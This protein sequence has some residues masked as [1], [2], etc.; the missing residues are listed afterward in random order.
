MHTKITVKAATKAAVSLAFGL[1]LAV[2]LFGTSQQASAG[3]PSSTSAGVAAGLPA[4]QASKIEN[5]VLQ[6]TAN[7]K[8]AEFMVLLADKANLSAANSMRDQDARGWYVYNT[9]RSHA[10][11]TQAGIRAAL[12]AAKVPYKAFWAIN[13]LVVTG[14]RSVVEAMAARSDVALIESNRPTRWIEEPAIAN[15]TPANESPNVIEW[16]VQRVNAPQV[17]AMGYTGQ[18]I[19]VANQDT[20]VR[21]THNAIRPKYRGWDGANANHNYN[22][23][24]AIHSGGGIC[25]PNTQAPCDDNGHGT[26]TV[27]TSVGE[28]ST[29]T[30]QI[31]V[32]PG[33]KW[34][35]CRNMN[36]GNGTPAT[37][38]ECFQFFIAPTDL[39]GQNPNPA[40]RPHVMNNSWGCPPSEGCSPDSLRQVIENTQAAGIFVEASAGNSGPGCGTVNDP[41]AIYEASFS[42]GATDINNNLAGFSSRGPVTVDGSNRLKPNISAPGVNV[43]S[44]TN[45]SDTSYS[46]FSGTSM[47]GPHVVGVVALLWS[48]RPHLIRDIQTTKDVLQNTA[49]PQVNVTASQPYCGG[50]PPTQIPNNYFG[51]GRVDALAAVNSVQQGTPTATVTGTPPTSTMTAVVTPSSTA[52][53]SSTPNP[54]QGNYMVT[55][56]TGATIVPG[57]TDTG[58]HCDDCVTSVTL[59]FPFRLYDQTY[60]SVMVSS[61][62]NAQFVG[63][64]TD[65]TNT[66]LPAAGFTYTIFPYWDDLRTDTGANCP[67]GGCGIFTSVSGTA[68]NRIFNIEWRAVLFSGGALANFQVRLYEGTT[69]S[70]FSVIYG[71]NPGNT[72]ATGGVQ[73]DGTRF[74]QA[75]CNGTGQATT[76]GTMLMYSQPPCTPGTV[77]TPGTTSTA[78]TATTTR[79]GTVGTTSTAMTATTTRTG[80]AMP[81]MTG[82][83]MPTMTG[84]MMPTMT[85]TAMPSMTRTGTAMPSTT[86][87]MMPSMTATM[88]ATG[89]TM[90]TSTRTAM[91]C[92]GRVTVC[93][94]TGNGNS[95]A[96]SISCNALPAHLRHGDTVGECTTVTRTPR[97]NNFRDVSSGD[98]F[99]E[100]TLDLRDAQ[101]IGGYNDGTFRPYNQ[102]TRAQLV[103]IVVLAFDISMYTGNE[104]AFSDVPTD[105]PFYK[106]I[107]TARRDNI[108]TGYNDGTFRPY[109]NV[110]RGQIAKIAVES[111]R[112]EILTPTN[113][114]SF[115]DVPTNHTF[116]RYIETA[117]ANGILSGYAD[118]KFRP[119]ADATRGQIT[120]IVNLATHPDTER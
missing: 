80:T 102:A 6:D 23:W 58:N 93:H 40:L 92:N 110:T 1:A 72:S 45:A 71:A 66:C 100:H 20:G 7:G 108:I 30:N 69:D 25:G 113:A 85:G 75:F 84:T 9:L 61:N 16:G 4:A 109:A 101:A 114:P 57:T 54:C 13:G 120:K 116:Y 32:A 42:T 73:R 49:N 17:W 76:A 47:A 8:T 15:I 36:Q 53:P 55:P 11:R 34:I 99:Y 63:S 96:I 24:D 18:G 2:G 3:V 46:N 27:G 65:Y 10:D 38:T 119:D 111:A 43:R 37:Y 48:A 50:T 118:G 41:P 83:M 26:H 60:N 59:P 28:D 19:V 68:P 82:T 106:Y 33:S 86:G 39:A 105:H 35:G 14:D 103:K 64:L 22:W 74:T 95:H 62:G 70:R 44:A 78:M 94:R 31:G 21:W 5:R 87:T 104:Q 112:M 107:M 51:Y 52:Q 117:Y 12:D 98:Y 97:A 29:Q 88:M 79:T 90:A 91:P 81:S 89:T 67:A 115:S 56:T 77:T